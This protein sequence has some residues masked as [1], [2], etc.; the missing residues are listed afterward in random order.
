MT[1]AVT[2]VPGVHEEVV[3]GV[4]LKDWKHPEITCT[5]AVCVWP[6]LPFQVAG[7]L[8]VQTKVLSMFGPA[9]LLHTPMPTCQQSRHLTPRFS[10]W[11]CVR[12]TKLW[13]PRPSTV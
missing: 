10:R 8:K 3:G 6:G 2:G 12:C 9:P 1:A 4:H 5:A 7:V 11:A 13:G